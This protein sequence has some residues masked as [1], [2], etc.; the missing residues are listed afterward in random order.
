MCLATLHL[1]LLWVLSVFLVQD[2]LCAWYCIEMVHILC[3]HVHI[4]GGSEIV[5]I[6]VEG[7]WWVEF[8]LRACHLAWWFMPVFCIS[9]LGCTLLE[10]AHCMQDIALLDGCGPFGRQE[11]WEYLGIHHQIM[12]GR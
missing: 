5:H 12:G 4:L 2:H 7:G 1:L 6:F 10:Q 11:F 3:W 8:V 9:S